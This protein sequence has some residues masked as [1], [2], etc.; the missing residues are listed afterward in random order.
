MPYEITLY[1]FVFLYGIVIGSFLNVCIYRIPKRENIITTRSHC[2]YCGST[3]KWK[4]LFPLFSYIFLKGKCRKCKEKI[5]IQYPVIEAL[6]GILYVLIFF[7]N[8]YHLESVLYCL[9]TSALMVLSIIDFRTYE[10]PSEINVFIGILGVLHILLDFS[11][12]GE[13]LLGLCIVSGFL[14]VIYLF[15][16]GKGVGGGDI[17]FM[18]ASGLMLGVQKIVLAFILGCILGSLIHILRMRI[19]KADHTLAFG[20]YL[21]LGIFLSMLYGEEMIHWYLSLL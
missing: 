5:S 20:P 17:K 10:I 4:D 18:A 19:R 14:L 8:G 21:S 12:V 16:K 7:V 13:Y 6:N 2:M 1:I 11:H 9:F 15:T 3:L